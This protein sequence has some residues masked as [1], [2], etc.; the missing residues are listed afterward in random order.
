M[1]RTFVCKASQE[2]HKTSLTTQDMKHY[3]FTN[4]VYFYSTHIKDSV[5]FHI[6][7]DCAGSY[8]PD[9]LQAAAVSFAGRAWHWAVAEKNHCAAVYT[10]E[11]DH[12]AER[13]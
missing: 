5:Y 12:R 7:T 3:Y 2:K 9:R 13:S 10:S 8:C 1:E 4:T 6:N 11:A